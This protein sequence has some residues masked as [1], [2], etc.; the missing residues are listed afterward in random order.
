MI[1]PKKLKKGDTIGVV[2][3]S[4]PI[5]GENIEEL[6][7]AKKM[8]ERDGYKVVFSKN[9]FSNAN[10]YSATAKEK[11]DDINEMFANKDIDMIWCAKGGENSNSVF[12]YLD[13]EIIKNN[14]KI[15]AGFSDIT[16]IINVIAN[17]TGLVTFSATNFKTVATDETDYSYKQAIARFS[18]ENATFDVAK[19]DC[20]KTIK[21]GTAEGELIG[22]NLTLTTGLVAGKNKINFKNKI[23]FLEEL[24]YESDPSVVS[25]NLYF[26]KQN[27]VFDEIN[28]LWIGNY[29]H[30][31]GITLEKIIMDVLDGEYKFPIIKSNNFGHIERKTV[32]PIGTKAEIDTEEDVKIRLIENCVQKG[33]F[34]LDS[35]GAKGVKMFETWEELEKS[36]INCNKCKLCKT[37]QNI[38]FGVGNKNADIMFIGEGP[39]ADE[40]RLGE[41]F[42]GR[43]GKLM[44][45][46]F[47]IVGIK[48][49]EV[50]IANIVKCRPP[51]NRNPE[52]D[53]ANAFLNYLR[54][55]VMLVKPKIIVLLGSVALKNILGKEYGITASRGKWVEKK[56]IMYM[57]TWH[58]AALLRDETKKVDFINDLNL[59]KNK[60][61]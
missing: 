49:D 44:N 24:G 41:P 19:K 37:R 25:R 2:A 27:G 7:K 59:V 47:G 58:P 53:E 29:E 11:A 51:A 56:G 60:I 34:F 40:D 50:Y 1:I 13:F 42:V 23:L 15:I 46:A 26:M 61:N 22:G 32:I 20:Y 4:N 6:E 36:I 30:E 33:R 35:I 8:L 10:E 52:D 48:R 16:S 57:P 55:Q 28:G 14:P 9:I 43:A 54:N 21:E 3:P 12:D 18:G 38:V 39:G 5:I 17:K 31:S 45:M